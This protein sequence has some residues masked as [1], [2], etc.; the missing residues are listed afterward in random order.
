MH[1]NPPL[2]AERTR[3]PVGTQT[4]APTQP[5]RGRTHHP[6]RP[7]APTASA[8]RLAM[9]PTDRHRLDRTPTH[10][11][12]PPDPTKRIGRTGEPQRRNTHTPATSPARTQQDQAT[13]N[14]KTK[15]RG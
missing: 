2:A 10:L 9:E 15:D 5:R 14:H 13:T 4:A 12:S 1:P 6:H 7:A 3:P 8:P 11:T